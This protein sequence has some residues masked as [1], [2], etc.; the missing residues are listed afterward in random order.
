[1]TS[2]SLV[3]KVFSV[4]SLDQ[5]VRTLRNTYLKT[6]YLDK[7]G[8]VKEVFAQVWGTSSDSG[9]S[10]LVLKVV[11]NVKNDQNSDDEN[12]RYV[13]VR[14]SDLLSME[15]V[16]WKNHMALDPCLIGIIMRDHDMNI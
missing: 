1:M 2:Q 8:K 12:P 6:A 13:Y 14:K 16:E 3:S 10:V 7:D 11:L 9:E 15:P 4:S 5:P